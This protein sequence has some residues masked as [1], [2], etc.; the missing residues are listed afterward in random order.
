MSPETRGRGVL[1]LWAARDALRRPGE[2]LLT[3]LAIASLVAVAGATL[4]LAE[5]LTRS[6]EQVLSSG[7]AL[8][9][10]RVGA[11][12]WAP[13]PEGALKRARAVRGVTG[14]E[15]R[16]WGVV[17]VGERAVTMVGVDA[18]TAHPGRRAL[19]AP[20][21]APRAGEAIAGPAL[22]VSAGA[23]LT[24]QGAVSRRLKVTRVLPREDGLTAH[25]VLLVARED[26]RALLGLPSGM[27]SDLALYVYHPGEAE[28]LR[29]ELAAALPFTVA[30]TTRRESSSALRARVARLAGWR[31]VLLVPALLALALLTLAIARVQLGG[32]REIGLLKALGWTSAEVLRLHVF[33]ALVIGLP[34]LALGWALAY[35]LVFVSGARWA[36]TLL[37]GWSGRAPF[38]VL[39]A[40]GAVLT[41]LE[42]GGVVL[43][44]WLVAVVLPALRSV[45]TDPEQ[46][47][48]GE[49][50]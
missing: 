30:I 17:R 27:A 42:V 18:S 5:G 29:A 26:A 25:D 10:R 13:M 32:R 19:G 20:L 49:Q 43:A 12:G 2:S 31:S 33:R 50:P 8:V 9:V 34:A 48:R 4:L 15:A 35:G 28:A 6:A 16:L 45:T 1:W 47:L 37:L 46:W 22:G 44:P 23:F 40:G 7:P 21:V 38:L 36:G 41:L 24:A 11:A 3:A 14:G 39:D